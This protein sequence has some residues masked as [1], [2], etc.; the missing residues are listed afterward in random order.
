[1]PPPTPST[2]EPSAPNSLLGRSVAYPARMAQVRLFASMR[3][4]AG[5][6]HDE[7]PGAT[8]ADI[9]AGDYVEIGMLGAYGCAMRTGFNGFGSDLKVLAEDEPMATLYGEP[10]RERALPSNVVKL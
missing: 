2:A 6:S 3:E 1:M 7:V 8:V 9:G 10:V 5:R 4:A